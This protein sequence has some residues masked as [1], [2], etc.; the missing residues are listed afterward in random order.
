MPDPRFGPDAVF[1]TQRPRVDF[2]MQVHVRA[3]LVHESPAPSN[4][5]ERLR[6][7]AHQYM[8]GKSVPNP[9]SL[10]ADTSG[11]ADVMA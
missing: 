4:L 9:T 5:L 6:R 7:I 1:E 8:P 10:L 3:F 11:M 2:S